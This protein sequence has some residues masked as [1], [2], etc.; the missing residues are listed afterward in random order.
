MKGVKVPLREAEKAKEFLLNKGALDFNHEII[1][2]KEHLI[3]PINKEVKKYKPLEYKFPKKEIKENWK[4][5]LN[6][7]LD[8]KELKLLKTAHDVVGSIA[9]LEIPDEL[10]K[11]EKTIAKALLEKNK[12]IK[13][14]LK[15]AGEHG[16][17]FRTQKLEWLTGE[18]TKE[19]IHRESNVN[20]KLNVEK[21]FFSARLA[22]ERKRIIKQIKPG[23]KVM[24]MF[25]GCAPYVCI[26]AKNSK[27]KEVWGIELNPEANKYAVENV[28]LNKLNNVKLIEGDVKKETKKIKEKFDRIAMPLPKSAEDFL[29]EAF[30]LAKKGTII[31]FYDFEHENEFDE[32][33]EKVR[34]ACKK[35]K[36]K[37]KLLDFVKCGQYGPGK[38]R[39]CLDFEVI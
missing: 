17:V 39:V 3:Y 38:F 23:E 18:K 36:I 13:T 30:I 22:T 29:P 5:F 11:K 1:K 12:T 19:T 33:K 26:F 37:Y 16:G 35:A 20:I 2:E 24:V 14:V 4:D 9:I 15:K 31:H 27:A 21:V 6:K 8:K 25:S 10:E 28:K 34:T 7:K 32:T